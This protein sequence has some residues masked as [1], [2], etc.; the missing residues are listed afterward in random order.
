MLRQKTSHAQKLALRRIP[1]AGL[2]Q[3]QTQGSGPEAKPTTSHPVKQEVK[4][5]HNFVPSDITK[6]SLPDPRILDTTY[7][8]SPKG[9][10]LKS[11]INEIAT[12]EQDSVIYPQRPKAVAGE[13][14]VQCPY[15]LKPLDNKQL[16]AN[17]DSYWRQHFNEDLKPYGCLYPKCSESLVCFAR[18]S[19]WKAHM[20]NDHSKEWAR[21]LDAMVWYCDIDHKFPKQFETELQWKDHMRETSEVDGHPGRNLSKST[22][23][24]LDALSQRKQ[25]IALRDHFVCPLCEQIP[26]SIQTSVGTEEFEMDDMLHSHVADHI[27]SLSLLAVPCL[28]AAPQHQHQ[29][30]RSASITASPSR[31]SNQVPGTGSHIGT[32]LLDGV[33]LPPEEWSTFSREKLSSL[34]DKDSAFDVEFPAYEQSH[35]PPESTYHKWKKFR[36]SRAMDGP[37]TQQ[38]VDQDSILTHFMQEDLGLEQRLWQNAVQHANRGTPSFWPPSVWKSI[39]TKKAIANEILEYFPDYHRGE[40]EN[41]AQRVWQDQSGKCVQ[42]FTILV[43]LDKVE[44]LVEHILD[45]KQGV[46]DHDL[47][48]I[49]HNQHQRGRSSKLCRQNSETVCC[50]SRWRTVT[51]EQFERFQR[52]LTVPVFSLDR[53]NN[54]LIHLDLDPEDILPFCEEAEVPPVNAMSGGSGTVIRVKI[55]PKCHG[56]HDTLRAVSLELLYS[57]SS[58][59]TDLIPDQCCRRVLCGEKI[60]AENFRQIQGRGRGAE[61]IQWEDSP[62]SCHSFGN[63]YASAMLSHDLPM[64]RV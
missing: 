61:E 23:P 37:L 34:F 7:L 47:P 21:K 1:E 20:I 18:R 31:S 59:L 27:Q 28:Y 9:P 56:F 10:D 32:K 39:V 44:L 26:T 38:D 13:L 63:I 6:A 64:G 60:A 11:T 57:R 46:R 17:G 43:L 3:W 35:E 19:E 25:K 5:Y 50:F 40:A 2:P 36:E 52:R 48:L 51:L 22:E 30:T 41:I 62:A 49:L 4:N 54:A 53:S 29:D 12:T 33:S 15:C 55:H 8:L 58:L 16:E 14:L 45:C 42:I 24:Q